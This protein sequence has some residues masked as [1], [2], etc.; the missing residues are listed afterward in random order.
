MQRNIG[1]KIALLF[2]IACYLAAV[3]CLVASV[4]YEPVQS[5]DPIQASLIASVIFFGGCAI[6][7]HVIARTRLKGLVS[8]KDPGNNPE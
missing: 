7:L 6:V 2:A 8:L 5:S 1:Q 3:G 4:L